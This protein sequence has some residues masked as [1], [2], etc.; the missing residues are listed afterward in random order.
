[1]LQVDAKAGH[2]RDFD[3]G[4]PAEPSRQRKDQPFVVET[5]ARLIGAAGDFEIVADAWARPFPAC[6][7]SIVRPWRRELLFAP[8]APLG[9]RPFRRRD[10]GAAGA[11]SQ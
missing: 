10:N 11:T 5:H 3:L 1:M 7:S 2:S 4:K 8:A 9:A 6:A